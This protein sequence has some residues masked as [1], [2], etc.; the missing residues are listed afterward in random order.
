MTQIDPKSIDI[1]IMKQLEGLLSRES[2]DDKQVNHASTAAKGIYCWI[3]A[4]RNYFYIYY[5]CEPTRDK[6]IMADL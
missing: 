4:V 2:L 6:L 3:K 1:E 5:E